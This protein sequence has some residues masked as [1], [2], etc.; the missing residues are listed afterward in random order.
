VCLVILAFD[1][2]KDYPLLVAANRD[3]FHARPTRKADWWPDAPDIVGGRDLQAGGTWLGVH[4]GGRFATVTNYSGAAGKK[5]GMRSRGHL[6]T[7]FLQGMQSPVEYLESIRGDDYAGFNLLVTDGTHLA[8]LSNRGGGLRELPPGVYG[9]S[10]ATLDEPWEKVERSKNQLLQLLDAGRV[11][12]SQLLLLLG[13]RNKG[14]V[15]EVRTDHLPFATA[16]AITAP[17]IVT[18]DYGTRCSTVV[19]ADRNGRWN[20]QERRFDASGDNLG[21]SRY[22]FNVVVDTD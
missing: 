16:H 21:E 18:A 4:R 13:D 8:Y 1:A 11:S 9:L 3:E 19:R 10:N 2:H 15:D 22:S 20:L 7:E 17:F 14:P 12:E 5:A 6:V